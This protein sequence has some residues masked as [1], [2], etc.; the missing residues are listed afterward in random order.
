M[1][2]NSSNKGKSN[3][4]NKFEKEF[5]ELTGIVKMKKKDKPTFIN[6][7]GLV[8]VV[9]FDFATEKNGEKIYV[10]VTTTF[11]SDRLKQKSYN[12]LM[13]KTKVGQPCKFYMVVKTMV[14]GGKK[15]NPILIEGIDG[16]I[17]IDE[18]TSYL[19]DAK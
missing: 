18:F 17:S 4:G 11:R 5:T 8:Q 7:H 2:H 9:D 14:E 13:M 16:V 19:N 10:D 12:A 6:S 1:K 15:K 3:N